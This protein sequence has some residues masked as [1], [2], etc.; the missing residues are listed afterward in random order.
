MCQATPPMLNFEPLLSEM[1]SV[2]GAGLTGSTVDRLCLTLADALAVD[3]V[4]VTLSAGGASRVLLGASD[5]VG[6][7]LEN[8]QL[9]AGIGPCTEATH[10]GRMVVVDDLS[11]SSDRW[12][13]FG[14]PLAAT[15]IGSLVATPLRL[16]SST[17][18]SLDAHRRDRHEFTDAELADIQEAA[19]IL[20]LGLAVL[21]VGDVDGSNSPFPVQ[22]ELEQ[23]TGMVL[24]ALEVTP[25]DALRRLRAA[26][27]LDGRLVTDIAHDIV[28]GRIPASLE[29][30]LRPDYDGAA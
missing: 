15:P 1:L 3:G 9:T 12:P 24:A 17:I 8:A 28:D 25:A 14:F 26:A 5:A 29:W 2:G 10:T 13:G 18:G 30:E 22:V 27:F 11:A 23:A 6:R 7:A 19:R 4:A 20:V 16:G 21:R